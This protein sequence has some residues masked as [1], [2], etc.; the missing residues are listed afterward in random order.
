MLG[1]KSIHLGLGL[2][3]WLAA[4]RA[5]CMQKRAKTNNKQGQPPP[6]PWHIAPGGLI[7]NSCLLLVF[8]FVFN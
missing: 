3:W 1:A 6:P 2:L 7:L 4:Q 8:V 5:G